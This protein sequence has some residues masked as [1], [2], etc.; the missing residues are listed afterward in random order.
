MKENEPVVL[1]PKTDRFRRTRRVGRRVVKSAAAAAV[2][3]LALL[4]PDGTQHTIQPQG[5]TLQ[6]ETV[7]GHSGVTLETPLGDIKYQLMKGHLAKI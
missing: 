3:T 2:G 7:F 6:S 5:I 4:A 1:Q